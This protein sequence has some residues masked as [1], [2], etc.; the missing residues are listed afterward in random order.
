MWWIIE[1]Q[2]YLPIYDGAP[3]LIYTRE[4][5]ESVLNSLSTNRSTSDG[6]MDV[7]IDDGLYDE[8]SSSVTSK[9]HQAMRNIT[10]AARL[11]IKNSTSVA[12]GGMGKFKLNRDLGKLSTHLRLF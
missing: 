11:F 9:L 2:D 1:P 8:A 12:Q 7:A 3:K 6:V 10:A 4:M 5:V